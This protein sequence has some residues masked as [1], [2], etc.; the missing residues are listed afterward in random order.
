MYP[1][2][3]PIPVTPK[4]DLQGQDVPGGEGEGGDLSCLLSPQLVTPHRRRQDCAG[5]GWWDEGPG[6]GSCLPEMTC[7]ISGFVC[8][9]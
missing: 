5:F 3:C 1:R 6:P 7:V 2:G 4:R 8:I 9:T